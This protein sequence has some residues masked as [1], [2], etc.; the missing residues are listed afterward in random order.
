MPS[1][2]ND[3]DTRPASEL[4]W[5]QAIHPNLAPRE[6]PDGV[7]DHLAGR[8]VLLLSDLRGTVDSPLYPNPLYGAH[9]RHRPRSPG[10][11]DGDR[12]ATDDGARLSDGVDWFAG[13]ADAAAYFHAAT[14]H[15]GVGGLGIYPRLSRTGTPGDACMFHTDTRP[16][17]VM[18][19]GFGRTPAGRPEGYVYAHTQPAQ[20]YRMLGEILGSH[21]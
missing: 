10:T 15:T 3:L 4:N 19:I 5:E 2:P 11:L 1:N 14:Q 8:A 21:A 18:W 7:L 12:H 16:P 6:F 17:R 13:W 9:V 20:Y